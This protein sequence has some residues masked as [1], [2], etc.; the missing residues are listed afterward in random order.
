MLRQD[1]SAVGNVAWRPSPTM[2]LGG[3]I[4]YRSEDISDGAYLEETLATLVEASFK[5]RKKDSLVIRGDLN[6]YLDA[7]ENTAL[8][9]P[10]PELW[11]GLS[12]QAAF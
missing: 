9:S 10:S 3:R 7:R 8:R 11:L 2:R 6:F 12:Y 1:I 4:R 5:L